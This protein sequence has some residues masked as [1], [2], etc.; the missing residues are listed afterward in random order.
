[1]VK[2]NVES[3]ELSYFDHVSI[4]FKI[5]WAAQDKFLCTK[6]TFSRQMTIWLGQF[7]KRDNFQ[8]SQNILYFVKVALC[9]Y[10]WQSCLNLFESDNILTLDSGIDITP[11]K[12]I[13]TGTFGKN[14]K[15]S[16]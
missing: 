7:W 3:E 12:N 10:F 9:N 13:A 16:P 2:K 5:T 15:R 6:A 11:G 4:S 8:A 14:N 1:M